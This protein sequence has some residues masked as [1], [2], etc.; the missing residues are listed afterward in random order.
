MLADLAHQRLAVVL[1]HPVL[2]LDELVGVERG[3][4]ALLGDHLVGVADDGALFLRRGVHGLRVH[5]VAPYGYG[6]RWS[7]TRRAL[8]TSV[9]SIVSGGPT[10]TVVL[11][12][13]I[14]LMRWR[15][16]AAERVAVRRRRARAALAAHLD[17]VEVARRA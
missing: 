13:I 16:H 7:T 6:L 10:R 5:R 1:G 4:E 9:R 11:M 3:L 15:S 17:R 8:P 12:P 14:V 2:G